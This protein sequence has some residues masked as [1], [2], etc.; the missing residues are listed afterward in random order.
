[1]VDVSKDGPRSRF[2]WSWIER[3]SYVDEQR[4]QTS[5]PV[6]PMMFR[7]QDLELPIIRVP[8][9]LPKYRL[10]N[11]R[12][13]ALQGE[14]VA[15]HQLPRDYFR[16]DDEL[17]E[18][19]EIQHGILRQLIDEEGLRSYF[20]NPANRQTQP[21]V[22]DSNGFVVNGNRRLC[23][24]RELYWEDCGK[25]EH[26][27]TV[28]AVVLPPAD[29]KAIDRLEAQ[30]QLQPEMRADYTW[31]AR[32]Q[33]MQDRLEYHELTTDEL[34]AFYDMKRSELE[35]LLD[36]HRLAGQY[37]ES[38][39]RGNRWSTLGTNNH[40]Y[41]FRQLVLGCRKFT[42]ASDLELF[43]NS[44]F[45]LIDDPEGA[46]LYDSIP[47]IAKH[48]DALKA[49]LAQT[50][51]IEPAVER[52][53][54]EPSD[55]P[56]APIVNPVEGGLADQLARAIAVDSNR[57]EA[58]QQIK[59]VI[60]SEKEAIREQKNAN[61]LRSM[62]AKAHGSLTEARSHGLVPDANLK[63]V[64]E[65][66]GNIRRELDAICAYVRDRGAVASEH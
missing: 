20:S 36:M 61:Y 13:A 57:V 18:V 2:G 51:D 52:E 48:F 43:L 32:A 10:L 59:D 16:R 1:M 46:R 40:M 47:D 49:R 17:L 9:E 21:L 34:A 41:A 38:R 29:Q 35:T 42:N 23:T 64:L 50:L 4:K 24:Y 15:T 44:A 5:L 60:D 26:F 28:R 53:P 6:F 22:L 11:G 33:M 3:S 45:L 25:F 31:Y 8:V 27:G 62:L 12:T 65:Q 58:R 63:G 19:Q 56:L 30:L 7:G 54:P 66:V 39:G 55:D 37:L 14:Y